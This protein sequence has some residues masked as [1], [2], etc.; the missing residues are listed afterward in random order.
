MLHATVI[1]V[2][3]QKMIAKTFHPV[4]F[5]KLLPFL[6]RLNKE[7][8]YFQCSVPNAGDQQKPQANRGFGRGLITLWCRQNTLCGAFV[9]ISNVR[10]L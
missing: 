1:Y 9:N 2:Q 8:Y 10:D 5:F 7:S 3:I 6:L 4:D